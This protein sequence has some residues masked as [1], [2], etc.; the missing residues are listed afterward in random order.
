MR[1]TSSTIRC[2]AILVLL[3][4]LSGCAGTGMSEGHNTMRDWLFALDNP[5][6][7]MSYEQ[8][9][10]MGRSMLEHGDFREAAFHAAKASERRPDGVEAVLLSADVARRAGHTQEAMDK[11]A[12]ILAREPDNAQAHLLAGRIYLAVALDDDAM[13]HLEKAV[14]GPEA[15]EAH[16]L[17]GMIHDRRQDHAKA[18]QA[19]EAALAERPGNA[20]ALN[21]L[22]VARMMQD[23]LSEAVAAF[24]EA[25]RIGGASTRVCNNL[26][27]ALARQGRTDE[28]L[29]AFLCA[30]TPAQAH[31]N[32]GYVLFLKGEYDGAMVHLEKAVA[33]SPVFYPQASENLKRARLAAAHSPRPVFSERLPGQTQDGNSGGTVVPRT[34]RPAFVPASLP[35]SKA[36]S[37]APKVE[38][39]AEPV[40]TTRQGEVRESGRVEPE[41]SLREQASQAVE[42]QEAP[43][44]AVAV[45]AGGILGAERKALAP[46]VTPR[47][48]PS[49]ARWGLLLS[50][51][52]SEEAARTHFESLAAQ[53]IAVELAR[54]DLGEK[55]V[56]HRVLFGRFATGAEALA[57]K[58][59]AVEGLDLGQSVP[60][61]REG[62]VESAS[63]SEPMEPFASI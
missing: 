15:F 20:E 52:K 10:A 39:R 23:R 25:T 34:T 55:G 9:L 57:A 22:G 43:V 47:A 46:A 48:A 1:A 19:F 60:V 13:K 27:L 44:D 41:A 53:G 58:E 5:G 54:A 4:L 37:T 28:A 38:P 61:R 51:W 63:P 21:N 3:A 45:A 18:A 7:E 17:R 32:L 33:L 30:G 11:V 36:I 31:N 6:A 16:M 62:I 56:W 29:Q 35:A 2:L 8:H 12:A 26:G 24:S 40:P 50:S 49:G 42:A 14:R 59:S